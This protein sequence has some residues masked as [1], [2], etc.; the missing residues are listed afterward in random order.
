MKICVAQ[1]RPFTG[2]IQQNIERHK[3]F[4]ETAVSQQANLI[5][6]PELSL[7]GYEPTLAQ[8]LV[9]QPDDPRLDVFQ[10]LAD[11]GQICIG[12]GA[13]AENQP[14][15][16]ISLLIF[17][18]FQPRQR[19]S[20]Q[21]LHA[22]EEPFFS[23]GSPAAGLVG[24]KN[25]VALAICYELSVPE[26]ATNAVKRGAQIYIASVAKF[27]NGIA[28]AQ[29]RLAT[30]AKQHGMIVLMANCVGTA[31][32]EECAGQSAVWNRDGLMVEQLDAKNEGI[33]VFDIDRQEASKKFV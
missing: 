8:A 30:I 14:R 28:K 18:P 26:H 32:G 33:L 21:F 20:K 10:T 24:E 19:Y 6:F 5:I 22:D 29:Q 15:P 4:V 7:T 17:R 9:I 11:A 25:D 27:A 13:P 31:D 1:T 12:V 16:R 2:D 3:V 23:P